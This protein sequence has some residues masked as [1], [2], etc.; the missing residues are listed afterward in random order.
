MCLTLSNECFTLLKRR[1]LSN[2]ID[3][4]KFGR[5]AMRVTT[6]PNVNGFTYYGLGMS[7]II[8]VLLVIERNYE[9]TY[10]IRMLDNKYICNELLLPFY[11]LVCF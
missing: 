1:F 10:E 9:K 6:H 5:D 2:E 7:G 4:C 11:I 3:V 8:L